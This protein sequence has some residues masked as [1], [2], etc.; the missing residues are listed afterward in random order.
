MVSKIFFVKTVVSG[1]LFCT[2]FASAQTTHPQPITATKQFAPLTE[3]EIKKTVESALEVFHTPG[4]A[5]GIV[6]GGQ[7]K[8]AGGFGIRDIK[9]GANVDEKTLFR[10]ASTSKAFTAAALAIL[11]DDGV[12][13]WDDKVIDYLPDFRM[14]DA[15]VTREFTI[16]DL[17]THRSGLGL[18]AGDLM[19]W[20]EPSGFTR[21]EIIH[22]LRYLKPVSSF[23]SRY[24]YDN[25][26]YIVAGEVVAKASGSSYEN[27]VQK[28]I[29]DRLDMG[30]Y[31]GKI[32]KYKRGNIAIPYGYIEDGIKEIT[33]NKI[34]GAIT[35]SQAAGGLVCNGQ[36]MNIW[37]LTQLGGGLGPNGK[38]IFSKKQ[39]DEMWKSQTILHVSNFERE[40]DNT[41][42]KTYALGWRKDDVHGYEVISHTGT[43]S[44]MQAYV[45]LVPELDLGIAI[46]NNGSNYGVRN[47]VMQS[48]LKAYMGQEKRDWVDFYHERQLAAAGRKKPQADN[49]NHKGSG[50]VIKPLEDYAG[51][52]KD[53]WFGKVDILKAAK[54]L[55]F[56]SHK[57]INLKGT[58]EP[59]GQNTFIVRW[60]D[61][62][63]GADA[64]ARFETDFE[65]NIKG[66]T[67]KAVD[68]DADFSFDFHDLDFVRL[69]Q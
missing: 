26:L 9:S 38:R 18:G 13:H 17:L 23:R 49:D 11:V 6:Q 48:I 3:A 57:S 62:G 45:V 44:G 54:E 67:M 52:Y 32:P 33:R 40:F 30:C 20:P 21:K 14:S 10:I 61:R 5:L 66:L 29:M 25:L 2:P 35:A 31:A 42:F 60:D 4:L 37:M 39:R 58:L 65:G 43:L 69:E 55:R 24:A 41:H 47:G 16:R 63:F 64:Y 1:I 68:P 59:F 27:F 51:T 36:G 22:N 28:R 7:V 19:L 46:L 50:T 12:L 56:R 34:S 53:P 8:F 15:W